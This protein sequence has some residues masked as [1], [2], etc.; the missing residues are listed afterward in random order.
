MNQSRVNLIIGIILLL[1]GIAMLVGATVITIKHRDAIR[2]AIVASKS[3]VSTDDLCK[4]TYQ[5]MGFT[6][7]PWAGGGL[8]VTKTLDSNVENEFTQVSLGILACKGFKLHDF[9]AGGRCPGHQLSLNLANE[10]L[11]K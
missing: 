9:C 5:R 10:I 11:D 3:T 8:T 1:T 4:S 6:V 7:K 2:T